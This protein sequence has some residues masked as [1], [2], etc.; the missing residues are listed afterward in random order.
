MYSDRSRLTTI[1][2]SVGT[3]DRLRRYKVGG[4]SME[5]VIVELMHNLSPEKFWANVERAGTRQK[6]M[7]AAPADEL[8]R[9]FESLSPPRWEDLGPFS[10][11]PRRRAKDEL[12]VKHRLRPSTGYE[13]H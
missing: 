12:L 8:Y 2:V 6:E 13:P 3:L 11:D 4:A 1:S 7:E 9:H 5:D 10:T